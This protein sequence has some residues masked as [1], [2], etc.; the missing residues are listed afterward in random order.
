MIICSDCGNPL[1]DGL[2]FCTEC[3][4]KVS[5][6]APVAYSPNDTLNGETTASQ[7]D[8]G[9]LPGRSGSDRETAYEAPTV[10]FPLNARSSSPIRAG[11]LKTMPLVLGGILL[12]VIGAIA[13]FS[14]HRS[15]A[16]AD[17]I[18]SSLNDAIA[19]GRLVTLAGDDAYSYYFRLKSVAPGHEAL[20]ETK[21]KTLTQLRNLGED[22]I[23]KRAGH[24][25]EI[26]TEREWT[27][28]SRAFEWAHDMEPGDKTLESR[29]RYADGNVARV[30]GRTGDARTN[31]STAMQLDPSWALPVND[32]GFLYTLE[33]NYGAAMPYYQRAVELK[34]DW[35][36]PYNNLGTANYFLNNLDTA[37][38]WYR[39]ALEISPGWA[40]PHAWLGSIYE[41]RGER[42]AAAQEFQTAINLYDPARDKLETSVLRQ[43]IITNGG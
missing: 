26:V 4:A 40:T 21:T 17:N 18:A 9:V 25:F 13:Y 22:V 12:V 31:F 5:V 29:W 7:L 27:I 41:R 30:L 33:K 19:R 43:R 16:S 23:Q 32:L 35:D 15:S 38:Y 42:A 6:R 36:I 34:R 14:F 8:A 2:S 10:E 3:G 37:E 28:A 24:S 11:S 20:A 1:G 39:K